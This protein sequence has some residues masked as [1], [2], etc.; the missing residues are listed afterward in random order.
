MRYA[1]TGGAGFIGSRLVGQLCQDGHD[2]VVVDD[3]SRGNTSNLNEVHDE[4]RFIQTDISDYGSIKKELQGMDGIFH[5]AALPSIPDSFD[6]EDEYRRANVV[7]TDNVLRIGLDSQTKI[8]FASSS[9]VYGDVK[10]LPISENSARNPLSPYAVTKYEGELLSE[11]YVRQGAQIVVLRYFNV[12][13]IG[14]A[15]RYAGVIP[16]FLD[17]IKRKEPPCIFGDGSLIRDFVDISDVVRATIMA[18][19]S[20]L[21]H[22]FFNIGSGRSISIDDLARMMIDASGLL[23]KPKYDNPRPGDAKATV[24]DVTKSGVVL[25]WQPT[26]LLEDSIRALFRN[27][28]GA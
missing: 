4:I 20:D 3:L 11:D 1:V 8:V 5:L 10:T 12:I 25:G 27:Q 13:G 24:A 28:S 23:L 16:K 15:L 21:K 7:G 17:K 18:M 26:V 6:H 22:G 2:V 14:R 19:E 9:S